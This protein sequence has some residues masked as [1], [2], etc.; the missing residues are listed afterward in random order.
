MRSAFASGRISATYIDLDHD[1]TSV[2]FI[3]SH[4]WMMRDWN[5]CWDLPARCC[6]G[7][8]TCRPNNPRGSGL[9]DSPVGAYLIKVTP[10]FR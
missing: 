3:K 9:P 4:S 1:R 8:P 7:A 2:L 10:G 5:L 6:I